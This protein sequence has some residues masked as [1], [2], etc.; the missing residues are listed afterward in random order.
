MPAAAAPP[1]A[2]T[3]KTTAAAL[4]LNTKAACKTSFIR[5]T[6]DAE[7]T[8]ACA[9]PPIDSFTAPRT[10]AIASGSETAARAS[11]PA[12]TRPRAPAVGA[13]PRRTRRSFNSP[14]ARE[15]RPLTVPTGH[16]SLAAASA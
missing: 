5:P 15:S 16:R 14:R 7:A 13:T 11:V 1:R 12:S 10:V 2:R 3:S 6:T 9:P 8:P 4:S